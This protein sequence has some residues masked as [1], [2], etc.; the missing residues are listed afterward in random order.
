MAILPKG[1]KLTH[2]DGR[3][4]TSTGTEDFDM[5]V[6]GGVPKWSVSS[7]ESTESPAPNNLISSETLSGN[8]NLINFPKL[9]PDT[10][11]YTGSIA[12]A[13]TSVRP[14][15]E[16]PDYLKAY[17]DTTEKPVNK[18]DEYLQAEEQLGVN[19][20]KQEINDLEGQINSILAEQQ[21]A[22]LKFREEGISAG[23][24]EGRNIALER[25]NAI[26]LLPLQAK[27]TYLQ[28][29]L[30]LA[31]DKVETYFKFQTDYEDRLY[32]YNKDIRDK[33]YDY[34][35]KQEQRQFDDIQKKEDRAYA[36]KKD[37][38]ET[39]RGLA[40]TALKNGQGDLFQQLMNPKITAEEVAS[41]GSQIREKTTTTTGKQTKEQEIQNEIDNSL[42]ANNLIGQ[43]G[44]VAWETYQDMLQTWVVNGGASNDFYVLYPLN[45][46]LD[47]GNQN[48]FNRAVGKE[49]EEETNTEDLS[50][51]I[52]ESNK[53]W[54]Q[55][56]GN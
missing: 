46:W 54:W 47:E 4:Y 18:Y 17:L 27:L 39:A 35:T 25:E 11:N 45:R 12:S 43:D 53:P 16:I 9:V 44:K 29:N 55:F 37:M 8:N 40:E 19:T 38:L 14:P 48:E 6:V 1:T 7:R 31:Q 10:N 15:T 3:E 21:A 51:A 32:N 36:E 56:W 33:V 5:G 26:R 34:A 41:I 24:I 28:G 52:Q 22:S 13:A 23:A 30:R 20:N 42:Q 50:K 49:T 2:A